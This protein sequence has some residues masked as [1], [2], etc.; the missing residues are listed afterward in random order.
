MLRGA[1]EFLF[2]ISMRSNAAAILGAPIA[3]WALYSCL[4]LV[5]I[6]ADVAGVLAVAWGVFW[7]GLAQFS[8]VRSVRHG[9]RPTRAAAIFTSLFLPVPVYALTIASDMLE[10]VPVSVALPMFATLCASAP[11]LLWIMSFRPRGRRRASMPVVAVE[12]K[13]YTP[14]APKGVIPPRSGGKT[15]GQ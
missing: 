15:V 1:T 7:L 3:S 12:W 4:S 9:M 2:P 6:S 10:F 14:S 5:P 8:A 11:L 13:Q